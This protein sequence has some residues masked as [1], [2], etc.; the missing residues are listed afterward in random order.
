MLNRSQVLRAR[1]L[2]AVTISTSPGS[3]APIARLSWGRSAD[4]PLIFSWKILVHPA[5][6][7]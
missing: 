3:S 2:V 7:S 5:A 6:S 1:R 4:A